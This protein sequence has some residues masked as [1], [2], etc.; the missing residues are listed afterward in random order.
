MLHKAVYGCVLIYTIS[1]TIESDTNRRSVS[2][3]SIIEPCIGSV[4]ATCAIERTV[5]IL[6]GVRE[7]VIAKAVEV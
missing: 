2:T 3:L 1:K 7:V 4:I 5:F 6:E